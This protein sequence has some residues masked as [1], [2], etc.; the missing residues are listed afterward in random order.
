MRGKTNKLKCCYIPEQH[1]REQRASGWESESL[2]GLKRPSSTF[3]YHFLSFFFL[4]VCTCTTTHVLTPEELQH[5]WYRL[6]E[7]ALRRPPPA[8]KD[9]ATSRDSPSIQVE[10]RA[11][12]VCLS[13]TIN[14]RLTVLLGVI[15]EPWV[16]T[17]SSWDK[18]HKGPV[19]VS[20]SETNLYNK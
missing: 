12:P 7:R 6:E 20:L 1:Y 17:G 2:Q 15:T 14:I 3:L 11:R 16:K 18:Q 13:W 5:T 4:C 19:A 9:R 10:S 8:E